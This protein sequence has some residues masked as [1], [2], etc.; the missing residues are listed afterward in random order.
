MCHRL[1]SANVHSIL[2]KVS[3]DASEVNMDS[4]ATDSVQTESIIS[5][6]RHGFVHEAG[7]TTNEESLKAFHCI[8]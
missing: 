5:S 6:V 2:N 4:T 7:C 8:D 3:G 1:A